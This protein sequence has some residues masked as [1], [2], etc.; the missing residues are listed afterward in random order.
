MP[1][2]CKEN[3]FFSFIILVQS[4]YFIYVIC[5]EKHFFSFIILVKSQFFIYCLNFYKMYCQA[6]VRDVWL[7]LI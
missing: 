5:I 4:Q 7:L 1:V 6:K 2:I 3:N